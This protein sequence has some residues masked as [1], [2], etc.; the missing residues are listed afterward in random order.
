VKLKLLWQKHKK[1]SILI[2]SPDEIEDSFFENLSTLWISSGAS[3][4]DELVQNV[5]DYL[6]T[7]GWVFERE[8]VLIEEKMIFPYTLELK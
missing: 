2:D 4:S 3:V 7:K 8:E 1:E 5:I 6:E